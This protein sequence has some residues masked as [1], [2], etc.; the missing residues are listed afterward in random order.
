MVV[1]FAPDRSR[2]ADATHAAAW[3]WLESQA[4]A[5]PRDR[6]IPPMRPTG[7]A[8]R[9][10]QLDA[11]VL[12]ERTSTRPGR[13]SPSVLTVSTQEQ[14]YTI[15]LQGGAGDAEVI[16]DTLFTHGRRGA[17]V[18]FADG[19]RRAL[20]LLFRWCWR[21]W[22][23]LGYTVKVLPRGTEL[24][25]VIVR[26]NRHTWYLADMPALC[27]LTEDELT[28]AIATRAGCI[29]QG[30]S[31]AKSAGDWLQ[32]Y[33]QTIG[34]IFGTTARLTIGGTAIAAAARHVPADAWLWRPSPGMVSLCRAGG[35]FR[36]GY[37]YYPPFR[38]GA[39]KLDLRRAYT[40]ALGQPLPCRTAVGRCR[41]GDVERPG[42]YLCT[43]YGPGSYP[44]S[45]ARWRGSREGFV[46]GNWSGDSCVA[47]I[48]SAEFT[49]LRALG[50]AIQ[51]DWGYVF[52]RSFTL[53]TFVALLE[54]VLIDHGAE[55][56][57]GTICKRIG[58]AVYGKLAERPE[59]LEIA[60]ATERPARD[61]QTFCDAAGDE[62]GDLWCRWVESYRAHQHVDLA[63][64]VTARVRGRVYEGMASLLANG[65]RTI[66][67]DTD[68]LLIDRRPAGVQPKG[69]AGLGE[70]GYEG[71]DAAATIAGPRF[72][73]FR[74]RA[75]TAGTSRQSPDVVAVAYDRG[76]VAVEGKV[77]APAWSAG[78]M[79]RTV[80]RQLKRS[81][82]PPAVSG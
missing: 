66:A 17:I 26:K 28:R 7:S 59:R 74:G 43:V 50:Y 67:A 24:L 63:A 48:P 49:G 42:I 81:R 73:A 75:Y 57:L 32:W 54:H 55:S 9:H 76:V 64:V 10:R 41:I 68:G 40:W 36:G 65:I 13:V 70:W 12:R 2:V 69:T 5:Y 51:P 20:Q 53:G 47:V 77:M 79:V 11:G 38:G 25:A 14:T 34:A 39:H 60:A 72:F 8:V 30:V 80:T 46:R 62:V 4:V 16:A 78:A 15:E 61:W 19:A 3:D 56:A 82:D 71:Y 27:G 33:Q 45:L 44:V 52:T 31:W 6:F 22:V 1:P 37:V 23:R 18:L 29:K 21:E 58:N 35:A